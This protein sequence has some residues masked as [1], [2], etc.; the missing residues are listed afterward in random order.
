LPHIE[1]RGGKEKRRKRDS[2]AAYAVNTPSLFP[3]GYQQENGRKKDGEKKG[4]S[5]PRPT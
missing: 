4:R 5:E 2:K 1:G 3:D